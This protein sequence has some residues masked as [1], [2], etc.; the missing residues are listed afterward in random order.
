MTLS[1]VCNPSH[2]DV[3][4][5]MSLHRQIESYSHD[6]HVF[7]HTNGGHVHRKGW[8]WTQCVYGLR[9]LDMLRAEHTALGVGAGRECLSFYLADQLKEVVASDLYGNEAW[10]TNQG[11]EADGGILTRPQDF[12]PRPFRGDRLRFVYADGTRLNF[13]PDHFDL[14]WS[15]SSIEHFGGHDK[16]EQAVR[17][18]ARVT[19]TGG[20]VAIAT[21]YLLLS[22]QRHPEYFTQDQILKR[23]IDPH[24]QLQLLG[25]IDWNALP[26]EY[27]ADSI[28]LPHGVHRVRRHVVLN[29]GS[30]QWTSVMLFYRKL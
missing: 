23:L 21:E 11:K 7:Q 16:A 4:D 12:C 13:D 15:M 5:W 19:R 18:M 2:Y 10:T 22:E 14:C 28:V 26:R 29:D 3:A 30:V 1:T 20:V 25:N 8:E 24:P 9:G 6:K 27:L 17:E